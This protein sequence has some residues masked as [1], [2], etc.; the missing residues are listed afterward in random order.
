MPVNYLSK[1]DNFIRNKKK[2]IT[3]L[4]G[5]L[6]LICLIGLKF[7]KYNNNIEL[8]L[9]ADSQV[10]Q[11]M[12]FLRESNFS[13]K[14]VISLKLNGHQHSTDDLILATDQ[15]ASSIN[16][17]LVKQVIGNISSANFM[18]EMIFFLQYSPQLLGPE[19]LIKLKKQLEPPAIKERLGFIYRQSLSPGSSFTMP[20]LR[21]DPLNLSSEILGN[22]QKLSQASGYDI[23]INN[24]HFVSKDGRAAIII[25][26]TSVLLTEGFGSRK[27][28]NYLQ[29]KLRSVPNYINAD[30]IAGHMHTV[31][32]EDII[33]KDIWFTS[34][35]AALG[36]LLLFLFIFRDW[37]ALIIFLMPLG[38]VL[39]STGAAFLVFHNLS[40]F[41]IGLSTVIAGITIDYGIY[42]YMAVRKAG[43][44]PETL[45]MIIRPVIFGALTTISV[46]SV[47]FF[48]SVKGYHQLAFF[49]NF[50]IILCL[51]FALLILP[52]YIKEEAVNLRKHQI[53][54]DET[55]GKLSKKIIPSVPDYLWLSSWCIIL[56]IMLGLSTRVRFNNDISQ[57]DG[58]GSQVAKSEEEFHRSWGN[59]DLP[60]VFVV[61]ANT[62]KEAYELN[63][64]VYVTA[65]KAIGKENFNSLASIWPGI[66]KRKANLQ[67]WNEFWSPK[68]KKEF[69]NMLLEYGQPY[70]FSDQ[71][72]APF[73]QQ[74]YAQTDQ[75]LEPKGLVFFE[76]LKEQFMLK[77]NNTYQMLSFFPDERGYITKLTKIKDDFPG[78]FLVS[79][80]NFSQQVSQALSGE[81]LFLG[82]LAIISIIGLTFLLLKDLR[83]TTLAMVPV[84]TALALI[85][86]VTHLLGLSLN[87]PSVIAAMVVVG[88]VSDYG[89]F[90]VYYCKY[91]Y[92]AGTIVAVTLAAVTTLIGAGALIFAQ[93]PVLFSIGVTLV[94]GVLSGYLSSLLIIPVAYR[95]WKV[96]DN[97]SV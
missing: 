5:L 75:E 97:V 82:L 2:L 90:M 28:V 1:I 37:R 14:L 55:K 4:L 53:P 16:S 60:A 96:K 69:Q 29:E 19:S 81:F 12:R 64:Q 89:M 47:F 66:F 73:I 3:G 9:P 13:D 95:L 61:S 30:I 76:Q 51:G 24:G 39:V 6:M 92:Q 21:A 56:I 80:K 25:I 44:S 59:R 26:K 45:R 10:Q 74:L 68:K 32:N 67:A 48:S 58:A 8:M 23:T 42:V 63:E 31:K 78:T 36:F 7:I 77:K 94:T 17:P 22:I 46:F 50:T 35:I 57:F 43:N 86:G 93:H 20:F 65:V 41:V 88:I 52:H 71:A 34:V 15:L 84:A 91:R 83:L 49:S 70:N 72:F 11:S 62:L 33:K 27:I 79:R 18:Q 40:Y 38:A 54:D 85:T 87:I